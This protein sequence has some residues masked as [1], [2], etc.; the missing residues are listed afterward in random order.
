[1]RPAPA[2][3]PLLALA[4]LALLAGPATAA[5]AQEATPAGGPEANKAL[6]LRFHDDIFERGDLGA[7]DEI[8]APGFVLRSPPNEPSPVRGPEGVRQLAEALRAAFPDL[9]LSTDDVIAEGDRVAIRWT[10]RATHRGEFAG[11]P[12]TGAHVRMPYAVAYDLADGVITALRAYV[13]IA[14]IRASL[15]DAAQ[16]AGAVPVG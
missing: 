15:A 9:E 1:M 5:R 4:L 2:L 12:A 6:A 8:L 16:S 10:F 14:A 11:I 3:T 7:I 13:P